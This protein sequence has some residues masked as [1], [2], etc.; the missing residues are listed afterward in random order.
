MSQTYSFPVLSDQEL[1]PCLKEMELPLTSAQL[2]KPSYEIVKPVYENVVSS[3]MG[4][5]R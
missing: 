3:L 2:A 1:L 4:I 5:S